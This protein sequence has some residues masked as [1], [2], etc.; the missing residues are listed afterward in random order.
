MFQIAIDGPSG[1]GKSTVAKELSKTLGCIYVDTGAM[2][3]TVGLYVCRKGIDKNDTNAVISC[4]ENIKIEICHDGQTQRMILNGEDVTPYIR[5]QEISMYAS[6]VSAIP[7]VREFLMDTQRNFAKTNSV[8]M[9]GRDIGTV[10]F[11][12]ATV[13]IFLTSKP[14][15]RALRRFKELSAKG[16]TTPYETVLAQTLERDKNDESRDVA[17]AIAAPDAVTL[18]NSELDIAQTVEAIMNIVKSK[19]C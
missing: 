7:K 9:D 8:V 16:D 13:K 3:R 11:P 15:A 6:A 5:T 4:L 1:A 19:I 12:N 18:D 2:Y 14:E 10:I 17:P